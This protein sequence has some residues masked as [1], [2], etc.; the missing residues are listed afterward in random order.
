[1]KKKLFID[2][3]TANFTGLQHFKNLYSFTGDNT[4]IICYEA[5]PITFKSYPINWI[6]QEYQILE[7]FWI[8]KVLNRDDWMQLFD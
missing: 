4:K 7:I 1:M 3:G 5:N 6:K 2:C 8:F